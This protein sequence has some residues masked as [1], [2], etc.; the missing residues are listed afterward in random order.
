MLWLHLDVLQTCTFFSLNLRRN[1]RL[2]LSKSRPYMYL[3]TS[4]HIAADR[5]GDGS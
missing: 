3:K 1:S 5:D 4:I 2:N